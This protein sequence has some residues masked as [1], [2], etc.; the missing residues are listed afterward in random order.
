MN[1]EMEWHHVVKT[2]VVERPVE[3]VAHNKIVEAMQKMKS[4]KATGPSEVSV[5]MIVASGEIGV[6]VIMELCQRILDGRGMPDKWKTGVIVP[7]FK[8]NGDVM[9]CGSYTGVKMPEHV[10]KIV[11]GY[12][13]GKY[14]H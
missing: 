2:N 13:K 11:E 8:G 7:I 12:Q 14:E 6:K 5:E 4:G 10:M 3:K 1:E 9:S